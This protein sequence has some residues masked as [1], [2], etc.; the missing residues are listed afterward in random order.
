MQHTSRRRRTRRRNLIQLTFFPTLTGPVSVALI[1][2]KR[3]VFCF[4]NK[5]EGGDLWLD[6]AFSRLWRIETQLPVGAV[7][8]PG[9]NA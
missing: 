9:R 2:E 3:D 5:F 8:A 7:K 1:T 6:T 4:A